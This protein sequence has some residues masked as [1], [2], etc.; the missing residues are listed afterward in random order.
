MS[1][2]N[3][4]TIPARPLSLSSP[5]CCPHWGCPPGKADCPG[6]VC[7]C[8]GR[9]MAPCKMYNI[10]G[11]S[12]DGNCF[13]AAKSSDDANAASRLLC[14]GFPALRNDANAAS[15]L[16]CPGFPPHRDYV[17]AASWLTVLLVSPLQ[18][19]W[20]FHTRVGTTLC[21]SMVRFFSP[22]KTKIT[23]QMERGRG[24]EGGMNE[25]GGGMKAWKEVWR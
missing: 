6:F 11:T 13:P 7:V 20:D 4:L 14:S 18:V 22:L 8:V 15:W 2:H 12:P 16:M 24:I 5:A 21:P 25:G 17:N 19:V 10:N 23:S 9:Q 3:G 1:S